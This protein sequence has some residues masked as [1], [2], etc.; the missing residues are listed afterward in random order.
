MKSWM[1]AGC[2]RLQAFAGTAQK[3]CRRVKKFAKKY[4]VSVHCCNP[5]FYELSIMHPFHFTKTV[6]FICADPDSSFVFEPAKNNKFH[7]F[8]KELDKLGM[9]TVVE[10]ELLYLELEWNYGREQTYTV[11]ATEGVGDEMTG[12]II[13]SNKTQQLFSFLR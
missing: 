13:K 3:K 7:W 4:P 5:F 6:S 12:F 1:L 8:G 9:Y 11:V 10:A 2:P